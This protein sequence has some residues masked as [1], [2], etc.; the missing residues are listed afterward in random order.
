MEIASQKAQLIRFATFEVDLQAGELRKAGVKLKLS[1]Q[2]FQVL[3]ILLE[4]PGGVVTREELQKRLWPDTFV[5]VDHNL[6]TAINKIRE[7]LGDSSESPRFVETLPR[8]GYRF[9]GPVEKKDPAEMQVGPPASDTAKAVPSSRWPRRFLML[10]GACLL[11][12]A[13]LAFINKLKRPPAPVKQR[14]LTRLTFD[15]GLQFGPDVV[16]GWTLHRLQFG[17]RREIGHL[18]AAGERR[19]CGSSHQGARAQLAARLV[20]GRKIHRLPVRAGR[21][22]YLYRTCAG[23]S[24]TRKKDCGLRLSSPLV[25][26]QHTDFIRCAVYTARLNAQILCNASRRQRT[27]RSP[28]RRNCTA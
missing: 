19:R 12:I 14:T 26:R 4:R 16:T 11:L 2:P 10:G 9:I 7:A 13:A 8:R 27:A 24:G 17:S 6:N 1:G 3:A 28:G 21:W 25:T 23:G 15:D 22:R 18:G 20:A 5:D